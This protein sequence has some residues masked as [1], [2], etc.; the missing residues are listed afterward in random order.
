MELHWHSIW[1]SLSISRIFEIVFE[2]WWGIIEKIIFICF[3]VVLNFQQFL[4]FFQSNVN[5]SPGV[6]CNIQ[7]FLVNLKCSCNIFGSPNNSSNNSSDNNS[8]CGNGSTNEDTF[9][10]LWQM[11]EE[12]KTNKSLMKLIIQSNS[13][14]TNSRGHTKICSL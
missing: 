12:K 2:A 7:S 5:Y 11:R 3:I 1:N 10:S 6:I 8:S 13:V 14:I 4:L 9:N